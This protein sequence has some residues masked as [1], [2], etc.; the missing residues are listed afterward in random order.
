MVLMRNNSQNAGCMRRSPASHCC[1][2]RQVVCSRSAAAVCESPAASRAARTSS[3]VGFRAGLPARLRFGWLPT[4]RDLPALKIEQSVFF[5]GRDVRVIGNLDVGDV[6]VD[7][8]CG[9]PVFALGADLSGQFFNEGSSLLTRCFVVEGFDCDFK[10]F[11]G[12]HFWLQP[13]SP[14]AQLWHIHTLNN[15][16]NARNVKGFQKINS[17]GRIKPSNCEL[18]GA[19]RNGEASE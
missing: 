4:K 10:V 18:T 19:S 2:V 9:D 1:Q 7:D 14:E 3:G 12:V 16:L 6:K 11:D 8:V 15:T 17:R 13:L 5:D